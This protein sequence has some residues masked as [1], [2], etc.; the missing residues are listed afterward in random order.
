MNRHVVLCL[1]PGLPL[2]CLSSALEVMRHANRFAD[3]TAY[4]WTLLC[5]NDQPVQDG[6]SIW[7]H[8]SA[9]LDSVESPDLAFIVAGLCAEPA[10]EPWQIEMPG[11]Q[12]SDDKSQVG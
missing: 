9:R 4:R 12:A 11:V 10:T 8:P 5:E 2:F 3:D 1:A 7:W 6:N